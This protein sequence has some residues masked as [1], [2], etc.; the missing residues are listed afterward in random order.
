MKQ[1]FDFFCFFIFLSISSITICKGQINKDYRST[2]TGVTVDL[3]V[4]TNWQ[5][6]NGTTWVAATQAPLATG[7]NKVTSGN[8]VTIQ[9]TDTWGNASA[10]SIPTGTTIEHKGLNGTFSSTNKI[11]LNGSTYKHNTSASEA[12]VAAGITFSTASTTIYAYSGGGTVPA[13][14]F[15]SLT[16]ASGCTYALAA[17][18]VSVVASGTLRVDGTLNLGTNSISIKTSA[19]AS[20]NFTGSGTVTGS[21]ISGRIALGTLNGLATNVS[22]TGTCSGI[23]VNAPVNLIAD[24]TISATGYTPQLYFN[25]TGVYIDLNGRTLSFASTNGTQSNISFKNTSPGNLIASSTSFIYSGD[26]NP[27]NNITLGAASQLGT[28]V[29]INGALTVNAGTLTTNAFNLNLGNSTS[30]AIATGAGI[31]VS[32]SG[33]LTNGGTLTNSGTLTNNGTITNTS[34]SIVVKSTASVSGAFNNNTTTAIPNVTIQQWITGQRG[35]RILSNPFSTALSTTTVGT[36]NGITITGINDVKTFNG[37]TNTWTN[38]IT[39]IPANTPYSVFIRGLA[40]EVNG[41]TYTADS[42]CL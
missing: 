28:N 11:T 37:I 25:Q 40:S 15:G 9:Q 2:G 32:T 4:S 16:I 23:T 18:T 14:N 7:T 12:T 29:T 19:T 34:G 13:V 26:G 17:G 5:M 6:Y 33:S 42:L 3:L 38:N 8:T 31:T 10:V 20:S 35:Y 1:K 39:S 30:H 27:F 21:A 41:L 24:L 22:F 36:A